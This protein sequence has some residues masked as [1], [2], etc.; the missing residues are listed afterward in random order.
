MSALDFPSS[1]AV[2]QLFQ[3]S[4]SQPSY[5]WDGT[6][7]KLLAQP[8][9]VVEAGFR[10]VL[11]NGDMGIYRRNFPAANFAGT[12]YLADRWIWASNGTYLNV[13]WRWR[14]S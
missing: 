13:S 11:M 5:V 10:N 12:A 9:G 3:Q 7:W 1:P 4:E 14:R 6:A 2:G 8:K